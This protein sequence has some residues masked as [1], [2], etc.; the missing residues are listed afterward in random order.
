MERHR[1]EGKSSQFRLAR[2]ARLACLA[3]LAPACRWLDGQ[4]GQLPVGQ[5]VFPRP[6]PQ[7]LD[8]VGHMVG[9]GIRLPVSLSRT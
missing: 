7:R 4:D 3:R 5:V 9:T 6:C 1:A 2:T 8:D